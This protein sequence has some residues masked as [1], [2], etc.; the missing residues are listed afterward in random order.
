L[1]EFK[2]QFFDALRSGSYGRTYE[3]EFGGT[4]AY[5]D[6]IPDLLGERQPC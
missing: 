6:L 3:A 2:A 4:P 5:R 1:G